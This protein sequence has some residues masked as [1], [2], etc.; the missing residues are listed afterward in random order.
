MDQPIPRPRAPAEAP[1]RTETPPAGGVVLD[2]LIPS[3][4]K[5][6]R[7]V[8]QCQ[9]P[10]GKLA[11]LAVFAAPLIALTSDWPAILVFLALTSAFPRHRR[12]VVSICGIV[13]AIALPNWL[14]LSFLDRIA[15]H[16]GLATIPPFLI[17]LVVAAVFIL[18]AGLA[19]LAFRYPRRLFSR[20]P[21]LTAMLSFAVLA[22]VVSTA[23]LAGWSRVAAWIALLAIGHMLWFFCYSLTDRDSRQRDSLP[24]QAGLW[25]PAWMAGAVSGTPFAKGAAYLRK[26]EAHDAEELAVTQLKGLKLLLWAF[27]LRYAQVCFIYAVHTQMRIPQ[28]ETAFARSV[29]DHP[30]HWYLNCLSLIAA[31]L[32]SLLQ[33]SCWGHQIIACVRMAGFRALRN[34]YRPLES[35]TLAEFWN[36]YY[37]YF[38]E[39][40]VDMFFYPT[41]LRYFK[42]HPRLRLAAATMMAASV[43]NAIFHFFRDIPVVA[44]VGWWRTIA[45]FQ[46]YLFYSFVLGAG[47]CIS[48]LRGKRAHPSRSWLRGRVAPILCV[49]GFYCFLHIFDDTRRAYGLAEHFVFVGR[50]I[51]F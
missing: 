13:I 30:F 22:A 36:R 1:P 51:G 38:K 28:F 23:P 47:I 29:A 3:L 10:A 37:Y 43:G 21:L 25:R 31:F 14:E 34:T 15:G 6:P 27:V 20:R 46:T 11:L 9:R 44:E 16:E 26:I 7:L 45:G 41:Y 40:L 50:L 18:L 32:L 2:K 24:L 12:S 39:L 49:A 35:R 42:K 8:A 33:M 5:F 19:A 4:E 48:Q 17:R